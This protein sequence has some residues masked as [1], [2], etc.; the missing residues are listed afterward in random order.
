[1]K[2]QILL[3]IIC[4]SN[5]SIDKLFDFEEVPFSYS[6]SIPFFSA[7]ILIASGKSTFSISIIKLNTPPPIP[8]PKHLNICF[9]G[10]T[11]K[12]GVFSEV[13]GLNAL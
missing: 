4:I 6:S 11:K 2:K 7:N 9:D 3:V 12:E 10:E 13:K 5:I 8:H 1:M